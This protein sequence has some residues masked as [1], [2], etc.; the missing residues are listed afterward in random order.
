LDGESEKRK[1][2][3]RIGDRKKR[4]DDLLSANKDPEDWKRPFI[5]LEASEES[6]MKTNF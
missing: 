1:K 4:L 6:L 2:E 5:Y 3:N